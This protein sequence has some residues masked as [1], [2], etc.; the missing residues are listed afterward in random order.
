MGTVVNIQSGARSA[1]SGITRAVI[2]L[3]VVFWAAEL[4]ANIPLAVL[5]GIAMKVGMDIIDWKFLKRAHRISSKGAL[6]MYGVIGLTVFVDLITA[7]GIGLFVAN[8]ITI[9]RLTDL[10]LGDINAI[11]QPDD[12]SV[13]FSVEEADLMRQ[14]QGR[15]LLF[16]LNGPMIFG[17]AKA[18]SRKN[19]EIDNCEAV[20]LDLSNVPHLGVSSSLAVEETIKDNLQANR[21]V[22]VVGAGGQTLERLN[23]VGIMT[24]LPPSQV[25]AK[26]V[27]ALRDAINKLS[28]NK[29]ST[30][31]N[32]EAGNRPDEPVK[33]SA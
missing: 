16:H 9:R 11:T 1:L 7:V 30:E 24:H 15:I 8:V 13:E 22:Y 27:D 10:Q 6:I 28:G 31:H 33:R 25:M 23:K 26:R 5:A 20:I 2:L 3:L 4:T 19:I 29:K 12:T 32:S 14:G 18:I 17:A 21:Q